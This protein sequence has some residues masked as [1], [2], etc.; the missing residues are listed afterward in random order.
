MLSLIAATDRV[1]RAVQTPGWTNPFGSRRRASTRWTALTRS[2]RARRADPRT[3]R[4][5]D[6]VFIAG[7]L[8][9]PGAT[10]SADAVRLPS[11]RLPKLA[12]SFLLEVGASWPDAGAN[13]AI[14]ASLRGDVT[15]PLE[16][17]YVE[18]NTSGPTR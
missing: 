10:F 15:P 8:H 11:R 4:L 18:T 6:D 2:P 13:L 1:E 5:V 9:R 14:A 16:G 17:Y 7:R 3:R 12:A